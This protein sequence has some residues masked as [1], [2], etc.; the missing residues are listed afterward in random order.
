[1]GQ[2]LAKQGDQITAT[3]IH[4]VL[5]PDPPG[6]PVPKPLPH[7]FNGMLDGQLSPDV[8]I[9]GRGAATVG[10]TATNLPP[11][12]PAVMPGTFQNP[13]S[14]QGSVLMGSASV[15]ING[16]A[17]ARNGDQAQTCADP[18]PN[19]NAKVVAV[20]TVLAGG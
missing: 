8:F 11:H 6:Q 2:P 16:K 10:S 18:L 13:P 17:A 9:A 1:M 12:L 19:Q 15:F 14:N 3:D 5:V 20:G 4:I 7:A